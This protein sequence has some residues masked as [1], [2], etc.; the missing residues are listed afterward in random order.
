MS[1]GDMIRGS[2]SLPPV[3][4]T[5]CVKEDKPPP[6]NSRL[7]FPLPRIH[8]QNFFHCLQTFFHYACLSSRLTPVMTPT[9]SVMSGTQT[10][11]RR[12]ETKVD[13]RRS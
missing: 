6:S 13:R 1:V 7:F 9:F 10:I 4:G 5:V 2:R 12:V 3:A 8:T 11:L